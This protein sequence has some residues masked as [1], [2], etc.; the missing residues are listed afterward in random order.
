MLDRPTAAI[1]LDRETLVARFDGIRQFARGGRRAPHKPLLLLYALP[2][3]KHDSQTEIRFNA[4]EAVLQP[5]LR[6]YAPWGSAAHVSYPYSRLVNDGLWRLPDRAD[7]VDAKGNVREGIA[8]QRDAPAGFAPDVLATFERA[9]ELIDVAALHLLERHFAPGLHEEILE[10]VGLELGTP[11]AIRRR[12]ATFRAAVLEAYLAECCI[13]GFSLRLVDGLIAVDAAH[14]RWH[15][16]GG[17]DEVPNGLAL[18]ALHHRLFDHGA[19]TVREDLRLRVA[20]TLAG[21]SARHLFDELDG[22]AV[23]L[24][25]D[26]QF[27]PNPE[28]LHWHHTQVIQGQM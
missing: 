27:Y 8:R 17:P 26:R 24:P 1:P 6:S 15:A 11:V 5:L 25:I 21:S 22:Q 20:R 16:Q 13:C 18:C 2:R 14:I 12:D 4:T 7:L 19:I 10:A 3:L 23:R 28:H 9:P